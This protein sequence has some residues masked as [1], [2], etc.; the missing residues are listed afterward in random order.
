MIEGAVNL[1]EIDLVRTGD[2]AVAVDIGHVP[3]KLRGI[4]RATVVRATRTDQCEYYPIPLTAP[5]PK[6][7]IPLRPKDSDVVLELQPLIEAAYTNGGYSS[8]IDYSKS[9]LLPLP[10]VVADWVSDWL[11]KNP[12]A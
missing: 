11:K 7:K 5:L 8:D 1:V 3:V 10:K 4:Y 2:W 6:I 12:V 9:P